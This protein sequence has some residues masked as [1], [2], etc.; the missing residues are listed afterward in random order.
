MGISIRIYLFLDNGTVKGVPRRIC[1]ALPFGEDAI[2]EYAGTRQR[3]VQVL[4][5]NNDRQP[6][7]ILDATCH[8]WDFDDEGKID[9]GLRQSAGEWMNFAFSRD[10]P[11][12]GKVVDLVPEIRKKEMHDKHR[13]T[14]A[15]DEVDLVA[16][17]IWPGVHGPAPEVTSVTGKAPKKPP[18]TYDAKHALGGNCPE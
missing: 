9:R 18:L 16:A 14:L 4:V 6:V 5:E 2:P 17:D 1:E 11:R 12:K 13:W 15:N 3:M 10:K 8:Y 7:R